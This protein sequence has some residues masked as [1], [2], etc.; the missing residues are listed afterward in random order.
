MLIQH[1][2]M[3]GLENLMGEDGCFEEGLDTDIPQ[4]CACCG[5]EEEAVESAATQPLPAEASN[6]V[7]EPVC[8]IADIIDVTDISEEAMLRLAKDF[9]DLDVSAD[10]V[11]QGEDQRVEPPC[12]GEGV[13]GWQY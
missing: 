6:P 5:Q 1:D 3:E 10:L 9:D 7:V 2:P 8:G 13:L 4:C 11:D 12:L